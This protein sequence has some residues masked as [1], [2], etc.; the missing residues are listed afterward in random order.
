MTSSMS[1]TGPRPDSGESAMTR[2]RASVLRRSVAFG[3]FAGLVLAG[4]AVRTSVYGEPRFLVPIVTIALL[5]VM[6]A[7]ADWDGLMEKPFAGW[8]SW[9]WI[10]GVT[11]ST[12]VIATVSELSL[13]CQPIFFALVALS[14]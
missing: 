2:F 4:Q 7:L 8:I 11:L 12:G 1:T 9:G 5:L 3:W 10:V 14:G 13:V 6:S